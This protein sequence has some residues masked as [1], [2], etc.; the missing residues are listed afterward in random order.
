MNPVIVLGCGYV[1]ARLTRAA[2][3]EG[4]VVRACARSTGRLAPLAALGAQVKHVDASVPK[5]FVAATSGLPGA[6]VVYSIP[7]V[8]LPPGM[9]VRAALQAA[10]GGGAACVVYL[11]SS[12]L[13]G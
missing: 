12:G 10:H 3:A 6:I 4:R 11:G 8:G 2:L 13:Y 7:P 5:S 9:A 1:G